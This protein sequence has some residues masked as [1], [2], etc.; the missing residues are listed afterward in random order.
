MWPCS[1]S[2]LVQCSLTG[3]MTASLGQVR[4]FHGAAVFG[5]E[6]RREQPFDILFGHARAVVFHDDVPE[7]VLHRLAQR[8]DDVS[9]RRVADGLHGVPEQVHEHAGKL[10]LGA[11]HDNVGQAQIVE[12]DILL[13][14]EHRNLFAEQLVQFDPGGLFGIELGEGGEF[15]RRFGQDIDVVEDH[16]AGLLE[17]GLPRR[18]ALFLEAD[19]PLQL[20]FHRG[21]R[22]LDLVRHL[23]RHAAPGLVA[24]RLGQLASS[25]T[26]RL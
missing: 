15:V 23:A 12:A 22:V 5:G 21:E 8:H 2:A 6:V 19:H 26:I 11:F 3:V 14:V 7:A 1:V 24:L 9:V 17:T 18:I 16:A 20:E 4:V 13:V 25:V 10:R